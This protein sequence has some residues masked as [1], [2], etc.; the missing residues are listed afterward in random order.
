VTPPSNDDSAFWNLNA[1]ARVLLVGDDDEFTH[2]LADLLEGHGHQVTTSVT[3]RAALFNLR[4]N[5]CDVVVVDLGAM[6]F[7]GVEVALALR[8]PD[9]VLPSVIA[10]SAMPNVEQHCRALGVTRHVAPPFRFYELV[11]QIDRELATRREPSG[12]WTRETVPAPARYEATALLT[13]IG[14]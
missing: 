14:D 6:N 8:E 13:V 7:Q 11:D 10:I 3:A 5:P 1:P 12:V 9:E 4:F 2:E